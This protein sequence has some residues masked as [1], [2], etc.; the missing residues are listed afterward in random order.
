MLQQVEPQK[1]MS[2]SSGIES[3]TIHRLLQYNPG[4]GGFVYNIKNSLECDVLII[5]ESSMIDLPCCNSIY[6]YI[7]I[8]CYV[9]FNIISI[10][11]LLFLFIC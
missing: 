1:R 7:Y 5:D 2:E 10:L 8:S 9:Y 6:I 3:K 11:F 4:T